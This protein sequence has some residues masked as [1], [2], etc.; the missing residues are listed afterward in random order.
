MTSQRPFLLLR[1]SFPGRP[2][3]IQLPP[4]EGS[5]GGA[6]RDEAS[7][8]AEA[9]AGA[10]HRDGE[11]QPHLARAQGGDSIEIFLALVSA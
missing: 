6:E 8:A 7:G 2:T 4:E 10:G 11:G 9:G 5:G 3:F 1:I